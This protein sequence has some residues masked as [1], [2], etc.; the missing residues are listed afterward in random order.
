MNIIQHS[1]ARGVRAAAVTTVVAGAS[2]AGLLGPGAAHASTA[3]HRIAGIVVVDS[4][5]GVSGSIT[6][7]PGLR[8]TKVKA[9]RAALSGK[10][11]G[12]S[13][14]TQ[15]PVNGTGRF[16]ATLS[17]NAS[18]AAENFKGT[19]TIHWPVSTGF[20]P[21]TGTLS[22]TDSNGMENV[23]GTVTSGA[24]TGTALAMQYVT[25]HN[26]GKGTKKHPV[27]KQAYI[28]TQ[29]LTLSRNEG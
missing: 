8:S 13:D 11:S 18:L 7:S 15:G 26:T 3:S 27:T 5:T 9:E 17:G 6:Y 2:M 12:C 14:S 25:T 1:A 29:S 20:N 10:I 23:S 21:S 16:T 19:F 22:V 28:N 24:D 4:C